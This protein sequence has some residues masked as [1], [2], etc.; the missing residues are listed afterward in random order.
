MNPIHPFNL[1]RSVRPSAPTIGLLGAV[2]LG[3]LT[4]VSALA[5]M[6]R[7]GTNAPPGAGG[8]VPARSVIMSVTPQGSNSTVCWYG[9][10]GWYSVEMSA[11]GSPFTSVGR[12]VA[13]DFLGG[14]TVN[15]G[16]AA[17][18]LFRLNQN[19]AFVGSGGCAGCHGDKYGEWYYT[20][21]ARAFSDIANLPRATQ[22]TCAPCHT[23]GYGQ[24]TGFD[25]TSK[26]TQMQGVGCE[27]CHGPAAWH[28]YSDH[29]TV[30]PAV[31]IDAKICGTCHAGSY[32][33]QYTEW[34][35][36]GHAAVV[37]D[38][39]GIPTTNVTYFTNGAIISTNMIVTCSGML[40]YS[41]SVTYSNGVTTFIGSTNDASGQ[42]RQASCG[43]CHSGA[44]RLAYLGNYEDLMS[45][46]TNDLVLPTGNDAV[47]MAV[48][49]AVC[50]DPHATNSTAFQLRNPMRS[51]NFFA[52]NTSLPFAEQYN[53]NIQ[54]CGQCHN[55]RGATWDGSASRPPHHSPQ[56]NMLIGIVQ[57][58]YLTTDAS[59][60]ATNFIARHGVGVSSTSGNYNT[61]QC[62]TCHVPIYQA[63]NNN[64]VAHITGH[65]FALDTNGCALGGCHLSGVPNIEEFQ[66]TTTNSIT[67]AVALL[68]Y[69]GVTYAPALGLTKGSNNWEY[70]FTG[71]LAPVSPNTA[72]AGPSSSQQNLIPAAIKQARFNVY[73]AFHDGSLGVHNPNFTP[74]LLSD[75][76]N[77]I[78]NT[79]SGATNT[80][81]FAAN[82]T[83]GYIPF[84]PTFTCYGAGVTNYSWDF[85]GGNTSTAA[86]PSFTYTTRGT[87]TVGLT[88]IAK[89]VT[90]TYYRTNYISAYVQPV[91]SFTAGP[92]TGK[93]PLTVTFTNTSTGTNDVTAWRWTPKTSTNVS[94][95]ASVWSYTYTAAGTNN[96]SLRATT[97]VG[98]I[99]TTSNAF[100]I[101]TP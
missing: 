48:T 90:T 43:P 41:N 2:I 101:V 47:D 99:T 63:T 67:A 24:P 100:I 29:D 22:V 60:Y 36:S 14:L 96:V 87:N 74:F 65:T 38:V 35:T 17:A 68:N 27:S 5:D 89:G 7:T 25:F 53:P 21:H 75:A 64:V 76:S 82:T 92:L 37:P 94:T 19:N 62:A 72:N 69:W 70:T 6:Y 44:T 57:T 81:Y 26:T 49:C 71:G 12:T 73:M 1:H 46:V 93:A 98:N 33:P 42:S 9:M 3:A 34:V 84:T 31:S 83:K 80:A 39:A 54:I 28:K 61:N 78:V 20:A 16:G 23:V 18:P 40:N 58:N 50:H 8:G 95:N 97:P 52:L 32:N 85:G 30:H 4:G 88:V 10:Q 56:Y 59:G 15:N 51:T 13:S 66:T 55:H 77:K 91:P 79:I 45:G 86:S 11:N